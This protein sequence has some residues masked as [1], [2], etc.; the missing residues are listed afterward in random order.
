LEKGFPAS[1]SCCGVSLLMMPVP[2][3]HPGQRIL[4]ARPHFAVALFSSRAVKVFSPMRTL[5]E[6]MADRLSLPLFAA[7]ND[8]ADAMLMQR[9]N[10]VVILIGDIVRW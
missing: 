2:L 7:C 8:I 10:R 9:N 5:I 4:I 1:P 6:V 3:K